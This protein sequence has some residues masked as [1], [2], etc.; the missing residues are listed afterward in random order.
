MITQEYLER[1]LNYDK[2]TGVFTWRTSRG[3]R[4]KN[5]V[6]GFLREDGYRGISVDGRIYGAGRLAWLYCKGEM[7]KNQIDHRNHRTDDNRICNLRDVTQTEN[8]QN[9]L[10]RSDNKS[11]HSGMWLNSVGK[12]VVSLKKD[13]SRYYIGS[14]NKKR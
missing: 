12:W 5:K 3:G 6:A 1:V 9:T 10:L 14:F 7:P 8:S 2:K 13:K 11:G 4:R